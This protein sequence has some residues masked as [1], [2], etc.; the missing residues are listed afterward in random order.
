MRVSS[1]LLTMRRRSL[2]VTF[3]LIAPLSSSQAEDL[4]AKLQALNRL[5]PEYY[6]VSSGKTVR[7]PTLSIASNES[8]YCKKEKHLNFIA[9][10]EHSTD[11]PHSP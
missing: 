10:P 6:I 1:T 3:R 5:G 9:T 8:L 4:P 7:D 2:F 11:I